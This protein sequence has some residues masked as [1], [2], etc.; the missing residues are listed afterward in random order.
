M[1]PP[2]E[3]VAV[4]GPTASGKSALSLSLAR[5][6]HGEVV[7]VDSVQ[8]YRGLDVG[9]AKLPLSDRQGVPHHVLDVFSPERGANVAEFRECALTAMRDI[10]SRGK[11]PIL[12]G[13]S[14]MYFTILLHGLAPVPQTPDEVRAAIAAM[15]PED[16]HAE[17]STIDP[18]TAARLHV[19]DRQRVSRALEIARVSGRKPSELFAEHTFSTVDVVALVIVICRPRGELYRRINQRSLTMVEQGL[20]DETKGVRQQYGQVA[21]LETIGYK[22]ACQVLDGALVQERLAEEIALHTR[23]FAKRQMSY[24][25]NEPPKRGWTV[26]P[27]ENEAAEEIAGFE[28]FSPRAQKKMKSFRAFRLSEQELIERVKQRLQEPLEKTEVWYVAVR[29]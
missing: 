27:F 14:G 29:E 25:R 12:V 11:V 16:M 8:V 21:P 1:T 2:F 3:T 17:L 15:S 4:C 6:L 28:E 5:S 26:R 10:S 7:N 23:R 24:W 13:G 22:Q 19:R 20:L 18:E 9:S